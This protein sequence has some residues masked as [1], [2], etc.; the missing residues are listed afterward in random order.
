MTL[1]FESLGAVA[2]APLLY[3]VALLSSCGHLQALDE[4]AF[5]RSQAGTWAVTSRIVGPH[6]FATGGDFVAQTPTGE[7]QA[8]DD[9]NLIGLFSW[10]LGVEHYIDERWSLGLTYDRRTYDVQDL[11]PIND[12]NLGIQVQRT[13]SDQI[14]LWLRHLL[15]SWGGGESRVRPFLM[16][17]VSYFPGIDL[18]VS[19]SSPILPT[20]LT[21]QTTSE[22]FFSGL[23]GGGLAIDMGSGLTVELGAVVEVSL[24]DFDTDLGL[25][26]GPSEIPFDA[27]L[28]LFGLYAYLGLQYHL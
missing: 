15:P 9:G 4:P 7:Q 10:S 13:R 8:Q 18:G 6:Y 12:P 11:D 2:L 25:S 23:A 19:A 28:D 16:S 21:I 24:A 26:V 3:C 20:P 17:G 14:T 5:H 22:D 1:R 27:E